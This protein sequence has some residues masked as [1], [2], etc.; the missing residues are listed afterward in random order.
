MTQTL[1][2][3]KKAAKLLGYSES[4]ICLIARRGSLKR[5]YVGTRSYMLDREEVLLHPHKNVA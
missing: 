5:Y 3:V 4:Y 2:R 1:I